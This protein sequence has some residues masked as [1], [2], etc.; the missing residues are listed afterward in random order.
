MANFVNLCVIRKFIKYP[1]N[2][3]AKIPL[4]FITIFEILCFCGRPL[5][6]HIKLVA[7]SKRI[8]FLVRNQGN[9]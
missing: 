9:I 3:V 7:R 2:N 5:L 1:Y 8:T 4:L 6:C